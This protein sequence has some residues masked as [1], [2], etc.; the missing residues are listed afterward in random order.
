VL[1]IEIEVGGSFLNDLVVLVSVYM[2]D[3][4]V[5]IYHSLHFCVSLPNGFGFRL[6][7]HG[8]QGIHFPVVGNFGHI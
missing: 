3:D 7:E 8:E 2:G 1:D 4:E 6:V 5:S